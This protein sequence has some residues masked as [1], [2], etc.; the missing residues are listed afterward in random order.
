MYPGSS[1][2]EVR[3][4]AAEL[5]A[6]RGDYLMRI[7]NRN[8][9]S[10]S[11]AEEALQETFA[12]FLRQFEAGGEAP[13]L[14][15]LTTALK[16]QCWRQRRQAH[17]DRWDSAEPGSTHEEL[18]A[19]IARHVSDALP[20]AER[21]GER[22]E[23]RRRLG[24]L[25]PDQRTALGWSPRAAPTG[26]SVGSAAGRR[27]RSTAAS[28]RVG[29]HW[30]RGLRAEARDLREAGTPGTALLGSPRSHDVR[31]PAVVEGLRSEFLWKTRPQPRRTGPRPTSPAFR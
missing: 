2:A 25:K 8:A 3:R 23:A 29:G 1:S 16:R 26:R 7:A 11:D 27:A 12:S 30:P 24:R 5:Y 22:D 18:T 28:T 6:E 15:W 17:L 20:I 31:P 4:L 13:A 19:S 14:P 21:L 10:A 9:A